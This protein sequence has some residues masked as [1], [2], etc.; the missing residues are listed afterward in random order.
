MTREERYDVFISYSRRDYV[1]ENNNIIKGNVI[2]KIK[3]ALTDNKISFWF[4]EKGIYSGDDFPKEIAVAIEKSDIFLF[5]S[6]E[7]SNESKWTSREI[8]VANVY[9]KKIIPFKLDSSIYNQSI[10]L[11]I[12]NLDFIDYQKTHQQGIQTLISSILAY[13][14]DI[15]KQHQREIEE[16]K[17]KENLSKQQELQLIGEIET[18]LEKLYIDVAKID[19]NKRN[20][21]LELKNLKNKEEKDRLTSQINTISSNEQEKILKEELQKSIKEKN[22]I[23][24]NKNKEVVNLQEKVKQKEEEIKKLKQTRLLKIIGIAFAGFVIISFIIFLIVATVSVSSNFNASSTSS[25]TAL[26]ETTST[27]ESETVLNAIEK[28]ERIDNDIEQSKKEKLS[29]EE[30]YSVYK[31]AVVEYAQVREVYREENRKDLENKLQPKIITT[32]AIR[33]SIKN[34]I[35]E[36]KPKTTQQP[37]LPTVNEYKIKAE[38]LEKQADKLSTPSERKLNLYKQANVLYRTDRV[39]KKINELQKQLNNEKK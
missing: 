2:S 15:K 38:K 16:Q 21:L 29:N 14:E 30:L 18:E 7:N 22:R 33:D 28:E 34:V 5:I 25:T 39:E 1:D 24:E 8:G 11:Y 3:Q 36:P 9:D 32:I 10:I 12:A 19:L 31:T 27:T 26:S 20:L 23:V 37:K 35:D 4:D 17:E 6:T 13:K